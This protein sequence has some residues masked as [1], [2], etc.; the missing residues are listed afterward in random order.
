MSTNA[1]LQ[2][3]S[4]FVPTNY[5][6]DIQQIQQVDLNSD[7]GKELLV[8]LYQNVNNIALALNQKTTG[9][10]DLLESVNSN[11]YFPNPNNNSST[12]AS[13]EKRPE[14]S[15]TFYKT[16]LATFNHGITVT[17]GTTF[18]KF[19]GFAND[20]VGKNYWPLTASGN[21]YISVTVSATQ[22]VITNNS[23]INFNVVYITLCYLQ[24]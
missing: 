18:T 1:N 5:I 17:A 12:P 14:L 23:G 2:S 4:A 11:L 3:R 21:N 10:Y 22:V 8:R 9:N 15:T 20:T 6:W 24:N 16:S 7:A 19:Y 13:P